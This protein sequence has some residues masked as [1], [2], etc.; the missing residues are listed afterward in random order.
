MDIERIRVS[1]GVSQLD[2]ILEGLFIGDN[3]VWYDD[4]GSLAKVFCHHFIEAS[5]SRECPL[6]YVSFDRSPRNL[7]EKLG[8]LADSPRL[9]V[10]DC[11]TC[12][13]GASSEVFLRFYDAPEK[14]W[15]CRVIRVENPINIQEVMDAFYGVHGKMKGEVHFVFE[16]LT[17]MQALWGGEEQ[18]IDF[19]A[20]SCPRLYEL[21]TVAYWIIEKQAHSQ[22]LRAK[23]N[24]IAQVAIELSVNR[25]KTALTV[26]KAEGRNPQNLN[27]AYSYWNR[28]LQITFEDQQRGQGRFEF[29]GRLKELRTKQGLSQTDLA[30]YIGVTP[31]TISQVESNLIYPSLPA[32]FKMAEVLSV[33]V[34]AFFRDSGANDPRPVFPASEAVTVKFPD[35]P[36]GSLS[37][38]LL[39]APDLEPKA[40]PYLIEIPPKKT[41]PAH[42]FIHK[43]EE[44]GYVLSGRL[45]MKL[46]KS[47]RQ[48]RSGD[49]VYLTTEIPSQWKNPGPGIARLLWLKMK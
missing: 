41:L 3:V 44:I 16:S 25:G 15:P 36:K 5:Q 46:K 31:S 14:T 34:G 47:I 28:D 32:L 12:G 18:I 40:E 10:L 1:T 27:R 26:I 13:K 48:I 11:F 42:F 43:G 20:H 29:G 33:E 21:R 2:R 4:A 24:Q 38:K 37:G 22:K 7:L 8:P 35:L 45:Q 19:Y 17:G 49:L 6:I 39:I 9:T 30:K 23:I